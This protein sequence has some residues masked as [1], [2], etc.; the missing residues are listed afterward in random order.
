MTGTRNRGA[1]WSKWDLHVHSPSSIVQNYGG[2]ND[3]TWERYLNELEALPDDIRVIGLN[4]YW[5]LDGYK[6]VRAAQASGRLQNLDAIFPILELRLDQFGGTEGKLKRVNLHVI[7]DPELDTE[8]IQQQFLNR[9]HASFSLDKVTAGANWSGVV[10]RDSMGELGRQIKASVPPE[11]L[12]RFHGDLEEG[13]NNLNMPLAPILEALDS[14]FL[15]GRALIGLGKTEWA[16]IKW[17]DLAIA[18]KRNIVSTADFL[19]TAFEDPSD[20]ETQVA[21]LKNEGV[22]HRLLDCS[23]AHT[24]AAAEVKDR[25]GAC[26]TWMNT[27][28][29]FA[30][31]IHALDE[32]DER[33]FVGLEPPALGRL[34]TAPE[35]YIESVS[36]SSSDTTKYPAFD[37]DLPLNS[38]FVAIVGNKGQGK[39][40]LLDCI[41]VAGNSSRSSE[42][43][44]LNPLRFLSTSNKAARQY[45]STVRWQTGND[46]SVALTAKHETSA[47]VLV[48]YLPQ[49]YVERVCTTDPLSVESHEF[50]DELREVLFTHI[51]EPDKAGET[52]FDG[53]VARKTDAA[54]QEVAKIR[55]EL[56]QLAEKYEELSDFIS[57]NIP[58]EIEQRIALK[59]LD[60]RTAINALASDKRALLELDEA[61]VENKD[62]EALRSESQS[63]ALQDRAVQDELSSLQQAAGAWTRR[64]G[65]ADKLVRQAQD[66]LAEATAINQA[67]D[68]VFAPAERQNPAAFVAVS[69]DL[70]RHDKWRAS[71]VAVGVARQER[72][73]TLRM[74]SEDLMSR[75]STIANLLATVDSTRELARQRV[76][77]GEERLKALEGN[78]EEQ[79]SLR[80]LETLL[81]SAKVAPQR[82]ID[83]R[84]AMVAVSEKIHEGL[85]GEL[86]AVVDLYAPA[87]AFIS[88]SLVVKKAG[89]EFKA[90]LEFTSGLQRISGQLDGRRTSD[91]SPW[92]SEL[93]QR[94]PAMDWSEIGKELA[95]ALK[96]LETERGAEAGPVRHAAIG[97]RSGVSLRN[98]LVELFDL[99][100]LEVRFG[101]I[102]DGLP[103]AQLSPGQRGLVLALFYLIVDRRTTPLLLDQP[104]ENLDNATIASLLVPAIREASARRQTII[105][106]HNANLAVVGDADQI[107]HA[108]VAG[109]KFSVSSGCISELDVAR[110]AIDVL[111]GTKPAFDNRRQK[112]EAF[113]DLEMSR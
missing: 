103:L 32:F 11:E 104:E 12:H 92:I 9:L 83:C 89:L 64:A 102:G 77:Q 88:D 40:A 52:S 63:I 5:F 39:S 106:T 90:E 29:S 78:V 54:R 75:T 24:W 74:Q 56:G 81:E 20:W 49:K 14:T 42:F 19:F 2:D 113:P 10:T 108:T 72:I 8:V 62:L 79:G 58:L 61:G 26:S 31:L 51:P 22:N 48:E 43:A 21:K 13:F 34:R 98:F 80:Q 57:K 41:A 25:L 44:F 93:P 86:D 59:L 46:R 112:Y 82:L 1:S 109:G 17:N 91:L 110:S 28:P 47:P 85:L 65:D 101:L 94:V 71:E 18:S 69:I 87:S 97:L 55:A 53:L 73:Q 99:K 50:E 105:V 7:F 6:R 68:A 35:Q 66:L 111:E 76:I 15:K 27:T 3:A 96:R 36:I 100:W 37:Y 23:D 30:G 33:V 4:D 107:V 70:E 45:V 38:G 60:V 84:T 95:T 67:A 16:A